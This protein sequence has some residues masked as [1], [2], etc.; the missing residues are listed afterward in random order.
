MEPLGGYWLAYAFQAASPATSGSHASIFAD[1]LRLQGAQRSWTFS[2]K[3]AGS[4]VQA[5]GR[6]G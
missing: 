3:D 2:G 6:A 1:F 5:F 4:A